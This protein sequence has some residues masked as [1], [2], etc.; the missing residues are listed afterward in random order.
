MPTSRSIVLFTVLATAGAVPTQDWR[1]RDLAIPLA[2]TFDRARGRLVV[3][4]F[5]GETSELVG[6]ELRQR[7]VPLRTP[8]SPVLCYDP[9]REV[10]W[11]VDIDS[12][13]SAFTVTTARYDGVEWTDVQP[14]VRPSP[15]VSFGAAFD[16]TRGELVL[17]GGTNSFGSP[18]GDTWTF[19]GTTWT[20]RTPAIAPPARHGMALADDFARARIVL[21]GGDDGSALDDTW[22]WDG[23]TW[24][25]RPTGTRPSPRSGHA[26]AFD[27]V[28]S[29]TVLFGGTS[30]WNVFPPDDTWE[31]DGQSWSQIVPPAAPPGGRARATAPFDP[32]RS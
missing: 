28:R 6:N 15:R 3:V 7:T 14:P 8:W 19:D 22:E 2:S 13:G 16:T 20:P 11:S 29:R 26:L 23:S 32:N 24:A 12:G 31:W 5:R 30:T 10:V 18:L 21:F 1:L 27:P 4:G 17:F 25:A 9:Q